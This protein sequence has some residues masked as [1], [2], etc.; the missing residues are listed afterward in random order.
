VVT[1]ALVYAPV[2]L[3]VVLVV[4]FQLPFIHEPMEDD[5]GVY[6][7]VAASGHLPYVSA[8]D[9]K[10]P[11]IYGWYRLALLL[12][13]GVA[14]AALVHG[15]AAALLSLTALA[16]YA[17]G[18][19]IADHR[20]G[21]ISALAFSLFTADQYLQF[22]ANSEVFALLPLTLSLL[23]FVLGWR[24]GGA[25]WFALAGVFGSMAALTKTSMAFNILAL[26]AFLVWMGLEGER[27]WR[28]MAI[29]CGA[30][31][32]GAG[33]VGGLTVL[34]WVM[35]G[36][37]DDFWF[38]NVTYNLKYGAMLGADRVLNVAQVRGPAITGGL[39]LWALAAVGGV[40]GS[41][42]RRIRLLT[43]LWLAGSFL[44]VSWT[45]R[46][47]QH[48]YIQLVPG[49]A[50][51]VAVAL[52]WFSSHWSEFRFRLR[53]YAVMVPVVTLTL[54]SLSYVY[55]ASDV[56]SAHVAKYGGAVYAKRNAAA[57][58][59]AERAVALTRE[60][61]TIYNLGWESELYPLAGRPPAARVFRLA[62]IG[63]APEL[64]DG[65]LADLEA[66]PPALI[67]DSSFEVAPD[68]GR[69]S[70]LTRPVEE[71]FG[72]FISTH[73]EF[74]ETVEFADIYRLRD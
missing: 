26:L 5:E 17:T 48:Y 57:D 24:R 8:F 45:G 32:V 14:S 37:F 18:R 40:A 51:L 73:Y 10:P 43:L 7:T 3:A 65:V 23:A 28:A 67:V 11:V 49:A 30:V 16:V 62:N 19:A 39:A 12:N 59:V 20:L 29:A 63:V 41:L 54:L 2:L 61:D 58:V 55:L 44:G 38:A 4:L 25:G 9:H 1:R 46:Q 21:V 35:A 36:H 50:L 53:T 70:R 15:M 22:N 72:S 74:V 33:A 68:G 71:A 13:R 52:R 60:G 42:L 56:D 31:L 34:P 27:S 69:Y 64:L 66:A 47:Y 6:F